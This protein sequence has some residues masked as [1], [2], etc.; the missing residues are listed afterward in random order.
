MAENGSSESSELWGGLI[1][2][3]Q[4][5]VVRTVLAGAV[6]G[7]V[8]WVLSVAIKN[9]VLVPVFCGSGACT[10]APNTAANIASVIVALAGVLVLVRLS[11]YRPLLIVL[12]VLISLWGI[13]GWTAH[14]SWYE[15]LAWWA[16]LYALCY[17]TYSWL[18]RPREFVPTIILVVVAV[19]LIRV[20]PLL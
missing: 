16:V 15:A 19:I 9:M 1:D 3:P 4:Q 17:L 20:L 10:D 6:L 5:T 18:V 12:A 8:G 14:L 2:V 7:I 11:V 13:G